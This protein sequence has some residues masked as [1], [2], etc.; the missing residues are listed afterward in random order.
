MKPTHADTPRRRDPVELLI[1]RILSRGFAGTVVTGA[2]GLGVG[3]T[4]EHRIEPADSGVPV[5]D[6]RVGSGDIDSGS[7]VPVAQDAGTPVIAQ[8][9]SVVGPDGALYTR[10]KCEPKWPPLHVS[11]LRPAADYDYIALRSRSSGCGGDR[12]GDAGAREYQSSELLS[13]FG[14]PCGTASDKAACQRA[15][16]ADAPE[17]VEHS[18][19]QL[20]GEYRLHTTR[21]DEVKSFATNAD[22]LSVLGPIDSPDEALLLALQAAYS[23]GCEEH[24]ALNYAVPA[25]R[26]I[27]GGYELVVDRMTSS[28]PVTMEPTTLQ[29]AGDG[30]MKV[31]AVGARRDQGACIGR[32][33]AGLVSM[34]RDLQASALGDHL[35]HCAHLEEASVYA[36]ERLARELTLYRAP[37]ELVAEALHAADDEV[38]HA[39]VMTDL[40]RA[41]GGEPVP[42]LVEE[43]PLRSL[44]EVATE[45]AVEGCVRETFGALVGGYQARHAADARIRA[46]MREIAA[47]EA[48]HASLSHRVHTWALAQLDQ[49][50]RRRV[51][52]A[53]RAAIRE[54]LAD[55]ARDE[56]RDV[57]ALAGLPA[58]EMALA[59][60][61]ELK[62][63]LWDQLE[64]R[65]DE[66]TAPRSSARLAAV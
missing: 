3:C 4:E 11:R 53:Q 1:L 47:D 20:C 35:A 58:P 45:N 30:G 42:A 32:V 41:S 46:A 44:E 6:G 19:V 39:R 5:R 34:S 29:V 59:L 43:L 52:A 28:C 64:E 49:A 24:G 60:A 48:R 14:T 18:R 63:S 51:L 27:E 16:A 2:L 13:E 55:C 62:A 50:A 61:R 9:G 25:Y 33:P 10:A 57:R 65:S 12:S 37:R 8:D 36:F 17:F 56:L 31:V 38:R 54:L 26:A 7:D 23:L 66:S 40:A 22:M 15:L 21:G